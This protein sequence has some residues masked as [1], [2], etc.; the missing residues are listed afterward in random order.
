MNE[1]ADAIRNF[2]RIAILTSILTLIYLTVSWPVDDRDKAFATLF[3]FHIGASATIV[4]LIVLASVMLAKLTSLTVFGHGIVL[5]AIFALVSAVIAVKMFLLPSPTPTE[6]TYK[7]L[8]SS[9][10]DSKTVSI[11]MYCVLAFSGMSALASIVIAMGKMPPLHYQNFDENRVRYGV[12][13]ENVIPFD[14]SKPSMLFY[15]MQKDDP[16]VLTGFGGIGAEN[17]DVWIG[18]VCKTNERG[19]RVIG[20]K[21]GIPAHAVFSPEDILQTFPEK[22]EVTSNGNCIM[23][24]KKDEF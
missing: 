20:G 13:T 7:P 6:S 14:I 4:M 1:T 15:E 8:W 18:H 3:P 21:M 10:G 11:V 16:V 19:D 23:R 12:I 22:F 24:K 9:V 2:Y 17:P 5:T